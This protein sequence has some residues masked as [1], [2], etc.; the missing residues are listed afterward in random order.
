MDNFQNSSVLYL[1]QKPKSPQRNLI[2][3]PIFHIVRRN[4]SVFVH[5]LFAC[6]FKLIIICFVQ[7]AKQINENPFKKQMVHK[8]VDHKLV[9]HKNNWYICT[10]TNK[11]GIWRSHLY[12]FK[13]S[14][15]NHQLGSKSNISRLKKNISRKG[16]NR[17]GRRTCNISRSCLYY[18]VQKRIYVRN[19]SSKIR[20][21]WRRIRKSCW[22][23]KAFLYFAKAY[24]YFA[25]AKIFFAK[26]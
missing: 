1:I 23:V 2:P 14:V 4:E 26:G 7:R 12:N 20:N 19:S 25:K 22:N 3:N 10:Y 11:D 9:N 17:D 15:G 21:S 18:M 13:V 5:R 16:N 24:F 6:Y 8:F